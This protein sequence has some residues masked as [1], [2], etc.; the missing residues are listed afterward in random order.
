MKNKRQAFIDKRLLYHT[1]LRELL[2]PLEDRTCFNFVSTI[3]G[4]HICSNHDQNLLSLPARLGGFGI[5]IKTKRKKRG[6]QS[7]MSD[8]ERRLN[9]I[10]QEKGISN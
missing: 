10:T 9:T 7:E 3:R 4:S 6:L 2:R 1:S 5:P 8:N